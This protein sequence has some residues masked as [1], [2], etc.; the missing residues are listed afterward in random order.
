MVL[1]QKRTHKL[2]E[3]NREHKLSPLV[4]GQY[5][6]NKG[7]RHIRLK[8]DSLFSKWYWENWTVRCRR[9]NLYHFLTQ[10][11]KINS[12][13]IKDLN[14]RPEIIKIL[15]EKIGSTLFDIDL[16]KFRRGDTSPRVSKTKAEINKCDYQFSS[17]TQLC[18]TLCDSMDCSM[19]GYPVHHQLLE[20]TQTHVHRVGD[21]TVSNSEGDQENGKAVYWM[22][23][24][25]S[26]VNDIFNKWLIYKMYNIQKEHLDEHFSKEDI[27]MCICTHFYA[28]AYAQNGMLLSHKKW[29]FAICN[30]TGESSLNKLP[31]FHCLESLYWIC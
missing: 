9:L 24:D 17:V 5:I 13:W 14:V 18:P 3:K 23:E 31:L 10:H 15:E 25:I 7:V 21:V 26:F 2:K 27:Q 22:G 6:Y 11:A 16:T 28:H 12:K 1:A 8:K 20:L 29:C 30:D 4:Y 19:P